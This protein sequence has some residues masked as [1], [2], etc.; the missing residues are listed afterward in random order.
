V[1]ERRRNLDLLAERAV[2]QV[3]RRRHALVDVDDLG[4]EGL[5]AR[6]GQ[7]LARER[8]AARRRLQRAPG[9]IR[10][11]GIGR[12]LLV[13]QVEIADHDGQEI[14][15]VV[16]DAAGELAHRLEPLRAA[17]PLL[18]RVAL[19]HVAADE[20]VLVVGLGPDAGPGERHDLAVLVHVARLEIAHRV[21]AARQP[22]LVA[23]PL[24]IVGI[25]VLRGVP[26]DEVFGLVAEERAHAR[27]YLDDVALA[28]DDEDEIEGGFEDA[29]V[30][31]VRRGEA[32]L[33]VDQRAVRAALV[34]DVAE[35]DRVAVRVGIAAHLEPLVE[36]LGIGA[37]GDRLAGALRLDV[38]WVER[39]LRVHLQ[40]VEDRAAEQIA[41]LDAPHSLRGRVD[42]HEAPVIVDDDEAVGNA[43]EQRVHFDRVAHRLRVVAET[44]CMRT[45]GPWRRRSVSVVGPNHITLRAS[46]R[47]PPI[48]P[49]VFP[50]KVTV[51]A[52]SAP[53][54]SCGA[55]CCAW[56]RPGSARAAAPGRRRPSR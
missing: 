19:A 5:A 48:H 35:E 11:L 18:G 27:A 12:D 21:A 43:G 16:R 20:E 42:V 15:E 38:V 34:R 32:A 6:E 39:I 52:S 28:V 55:G 2:E 37:E 13:Q 56:R 36:V 53:A 49:C 29:L 4:V 45:K 25:E 54:P 14:V 22:H 30:D 10:G 26:A 41:G 47:T 7:E 9:V 40:R 44:G 8:G 50:L 31:A 46:A 17:Q 3:H 33:A 1:R 24:E 51:N 23:R